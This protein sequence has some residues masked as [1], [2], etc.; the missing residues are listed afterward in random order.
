MGKSKL[1]DR[2]EAVTRIDNFI[3]EHDGWRGETRAQICKI[4]HEVATDVIEDWKY[5]GSPFWSH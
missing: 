3:A 2:E 5:L 1:L 4:I